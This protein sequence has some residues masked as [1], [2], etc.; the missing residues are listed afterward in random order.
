[1]P[2]HG[3]NECLS[4]HARDSKLQK[5]SCFFHS[6]RNLEKISSDDPTAIII[7]DILSAYVRAQAL[8]PSNRPIKIARVELAQFDI[9]NLLFL[10]LLNERDP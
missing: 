5:E 8:S 9:G 10:L 7:L 1:V 2:D 4:R 6:G 3:K